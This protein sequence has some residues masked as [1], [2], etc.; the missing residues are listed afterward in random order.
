V[1]VAVLKKY[2]DDRGGSLAALV[3]FYGFLAVFPLLLLFVTVAGI[4]LGGNK[5]AEQRVVNS[6]L[7]E[8][9]VIGDKL[10]SSITALHRAT[11]LA[12]VVSAIGLLWGSLGVT[13]H[14]QQASARI[15]DV[16]RHKEAGLLPRVAHGLLLLGTIAA[17]VLGSAVLAGISTIGGGKQAAPAAYWAW[18]LI[19]AVAVNLAAYLVAL[20]ILAPKGTAWRCLLPGMVI[21]GIGWTVLE[22]VGGLLV[23]HFL[24]HSTELYG[25]FATVLGLVF[26]L[27][28]GS[29]LFI[30]ASETNVV[31]LRHLW[32]RH[33][34]DPPPQPVR[35]TAAAP[36][37]QD[38]APD[39]AP[40]SASASAENS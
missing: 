31:L 38:Q 9:P 23:S 8:F 22:T 33:L 25:L 3:T 16:P 11:P 4:V 12:F 10:A 6:A 21:G 30:Y 2:G 28:L 37:A 7:S 19:G 26:W 35:V 36:P 24:R 29:Q 17:A 32:P 13:N 18:T 20:H 39:Q 1:P 34:D 27:S 15:W 5:E 40:A 14:L